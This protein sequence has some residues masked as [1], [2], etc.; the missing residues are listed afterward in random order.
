[1]KLKDLELESSLSKGILSRLIRGYWEEDNNIPFRLDDMTEEQTKQ[2]CSL[3]K[4]GKDGTLDLDLLVEHKETLF[5]DLR[6]ARG[7]GI[8]SYN[9]IIRAL[10][11][12]MGLFEIY[13]KE[14]QKLWEIKQIIEKKKYSDTP[15]EILDKIVEVLRND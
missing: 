5:D 11:S 7:C 2:W 4:A 9:E 1:M 8:K 12:K 15:K 3:I 10:K 13:N 14:A 6:K